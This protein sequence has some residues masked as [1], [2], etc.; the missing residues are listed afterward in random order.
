MF[1]V[2]LLGAGRIGTIH[3]RNI[4]SH[5]ALNLRYV[6]DPI[7]AA[8]AK[9]AAAL[10]GEVTTAE[11]V[12]GDP[13]IHGVVV[14]SSTNTHLDHCLSAAGSG[15]AVWC[16]KPLDLDLDRLLQKISKLDP[17]ADKLLLGFQRRFD[18]NF[19]A[20]HRRLIDGEI[21]PIETMH[22]ISHDPGP[23]PV[24]YIKV[25]G[26]LFKDM[27]IHDFDVARWMLGEEVTSV[28]A[29]ASNLV[30]PAIG[31]AGDVDMA[32][33]VLKTASGRMC[34]ISNTRRSGYGYDQRVELYGPK[35][36]LAAGNMTETT[37]E[38]WKEGGAAADRFENFFLT[39]YTAAYRAEADHF[40]DILAGKAKPLV[41]I[42]DGVNALKLAVAAGR[43]AR[44]G[45]VVEP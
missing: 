32:K 3:G 42:A 23:P 28:Y 13:D 9:L 22:V 8:A 12:F 19:R 26:G 24:D 31:A 2:A 34:V 18:P 30:D 5:P 27:T 44:E 25:S 1:N 21:G 29:T 45:V 36:R 16:E 11:K 39:R 14:A 37:V 10:G 43:S 33:I 41:G 35:G 4:A 17:I 20:L 15:K 38:A 6:V 40:A 7:P